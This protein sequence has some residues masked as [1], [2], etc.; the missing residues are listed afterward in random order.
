MSLRHSFIGVLALA[1]GWSA[2]WLPAAEIARN[3]ESLV[4]TSSTRGTVILNG[5]WRFQ[6]AV[7][8][9][10]RQPTEDWGWMWVPGSWKPTWS[11]GSRFPGIATPGTGPA[12]ATIA[13]PE[14]IDRAWYARQFTVPAT[15][16]GRA[17]ILSLERVSTDAVIELNGVACG[18]VTWPGGE[19]D[20]TAAAKPGVNELRL[21]VVAALTEK[22]SVQLMGVDAAQQTTKAA[23]LDHRGI[24]G[25]VEV[26]SRP[27]GPSIS[28]VFV[29]TSTRKQEVALDVE[30]I[31]VTAA[32]NVALTAEMRDERGRVEKTFT[33]SVTVEAVPTQRT[34]VTWAWPDARRWD[35][36]Q[37]NLYTLRLRAQGAGI[38]DDYPQRFG[39]REFWIGSDA[40]AQVTAQ[41][42]LPERLKFY[43]NGS[44][45]RIRPG[46]L[47]DAWDL[48]NTTRE[49]IEGFLTGLRGMGFNIAEVWPTN[50]QPR[51]THDPRPIWY[52]A[53]D[54]AG[55]PL[56][57][58]GPDSIPY[59][60]SNWNSPTNTFAQRS[61][62]FTR[63][64][65]AVIRRVR[66]HPSILAYS[67]DGNFY[68]H[69]Q[70]LNPR[71]I[72]RRGWTDLTT[73]TP[74]YRARQEGGAASQVV[75][76]TLDPTRPTM[77][78]MG[79]QE[80]G[81]ISATTEFS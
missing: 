65:K 50:K 78:H 48:T 27:R 37:P 81:D 10:A 77:Y 74:V 9:A 60:T 70:D 47:D 75:V 34:V 56:F 61:A 80:F 31:G 71:F 44:E 19:V 68:G 76:K 51:G 23:S 13:K 72:G 52:D 69:K 12:W 15:W 43:L 41:G 58:A 25:D 16:A 24:I 2:A 45:F 1:V 35:L 7:G 6:P 3:A 29:R 64:A 42:Q 8:P 26:L 5:Q 55:F 67:L 28:D 63:H 73:E 22:T 59:V 49:G 17:I 57:G 40:G 20:L 4:E 38:A 21:L 66:N 62:D 32:G 53:A 36:G 54:E 14:T 79:G 39:F 30:F 33:T 46:L 18:S 11:W